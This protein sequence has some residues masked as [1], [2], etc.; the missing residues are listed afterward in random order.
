MYITIDIKIA[1]KLCFRL[2]YFSLL[3]Q[4]Q[5]ST[6]S[7]IPFSNQSSREGNEP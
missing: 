7:C 5:A 4:T 6:K 2:L 3:L 1:A